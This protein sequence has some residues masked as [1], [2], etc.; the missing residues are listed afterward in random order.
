[1]NYVF[2]DIDRSLALA[3]YVYSGSGPQ[4]NLVR[5]KTEGLAFEMLVDKKTN[6]K[7]AGFANVINHLL[8]Y[9]LFSAEADLVNWI[10]NHCEVEEYNCRSNVH[11][12]EL[13]LLKREISIHC[14]RH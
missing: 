3:I 13:S 7:V 4:V 9:G 8:G 10:C 14:L 6:T 1:M 12:L 5:K 2:K 11:S